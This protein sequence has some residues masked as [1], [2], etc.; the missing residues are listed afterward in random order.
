M[1][2]FNK[3]LFIIGQI[4]GHIPIMMRDTAGLLMSRFFENIVGFGPSAKV[5]SAVDLKGHVIHKGQILF[6]RAKNVDGEMTET[7]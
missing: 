1:K 2:T 7:P 6:M 3:A 5:G 4:R